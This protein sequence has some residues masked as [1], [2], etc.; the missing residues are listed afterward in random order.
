MRYANCMGC[1]REHKYYRFTN[2]QIGY[3][4]Y[5]ENCGTRMHEPGRKVSLLQWVI[6]LVKGWLR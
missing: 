6:A 2:K 5:C 1:G 3:M 4:L